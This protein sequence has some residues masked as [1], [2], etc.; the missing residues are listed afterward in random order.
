MAA[1][2]LILDLAA[3]H[4]PATLARQ[5]RL[6]VLVGERT[7]DVDLAT[8]MARF[9]DDLAFPLQLV[10][11]V[12][13]EA[14]TFTWAWA[15]ADG[16]PEGLVTGVQALRGYGSEHG[17]EELT[18][19]V[20]HTADLDPFLLAAIARGWCQ[21][22]AMYRTPAPGGAVYLLLGDV[23]LPAPEAHQLSQALTTGIA[24]APMDH[25]RAAVSLF[26]DNRLATTGLG[27]M[28]VATV[29]TSLVSVAFTDQGRIADVSVSHM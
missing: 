15:A 22:D 18:E 14:Q 13:E 7:V 20:W 17:I 29:G 6:A 2:P 12:S 26:A 23:P 24:L 3:E 11:A 10:G 1:V 27:E 21:A 9:G 5:Q 25:R 8:G 4:V 28:V 16:A 19:A